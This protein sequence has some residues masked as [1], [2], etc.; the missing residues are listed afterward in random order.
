MYT[1]ELAHFT[2][3][4]RYLVYLAKPEGLLCWKRKM[5]DIVYQDLE[6]CVDFGELMLGTE[7]ES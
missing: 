3:T 2:T 1:P 7:A 5:S 4:Y 6:K